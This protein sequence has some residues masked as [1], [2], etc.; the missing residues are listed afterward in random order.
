L[1]ENTTVDRNSSVEE[2]PSIDNSSSLP[3][4]IKLASYNGLVLPLNSNI[5]LAQEYSPSIKNK[6][7]THETVGGTSITTFGEAIRTVGLRIRIIKLSDLWQIYYKG[8][9]AVTYL[10]GNQSRY[11]GSLY[12]TGYDAFS[13][14]TKKLSVSYRY[15]VT[16]ADLDFLFKS[17]TNTTINADL[18]MYVNQDLTRP[19]R[20]NWGV[21]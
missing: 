5:A 2:Y 8:L 11:Y 4:I 13:E 1:G 12:L 17:E 14:D 18:K 20:N 15:K 6:I 3:E 21:L 19:Y 7:V 10:S 16:V 9:E